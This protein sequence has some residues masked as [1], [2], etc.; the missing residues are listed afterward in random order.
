MKENAT[1]KFKTVQQVAQDNECETRT[2]QKWCLANNVPYIGSGQRKQY[3]IY[4]E[5]EEKFKEREKPGRRWST[6]KTK[7]KK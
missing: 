5:H 4:P 7:K 6:K 3:M 2:V 1:V